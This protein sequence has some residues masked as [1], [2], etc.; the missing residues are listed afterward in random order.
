MMMI[1]MKRWNE[2]TRR[3]ALVEQTM[4]LLATK[5]HQ[6]LEVLLESLQSLLTS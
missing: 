2:L 5:L 1:K 3:T 6:L 4:M